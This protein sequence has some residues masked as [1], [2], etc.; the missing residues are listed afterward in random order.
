MDRSKRKYVGHRKIAEYHKLDMDDP[1]CMACG[2]GMETWRECE[3][4]HVIARWLGG[5]DGA[6]NLWLLCHFCH[7]GSEERGWR[8]MP[9]FA[10]GDEAAAD[11][12]LASHPTWSDG[13]EHMLKEI[14]VMVE[15]ANGDLGLAKTALLGH[16]E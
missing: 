11:L 10:P 7:R 4:A 9:D 2:E 13:I 12:W 16:L 14:Q 5:L 8:S 6:Q 1:S 3:R 15:A